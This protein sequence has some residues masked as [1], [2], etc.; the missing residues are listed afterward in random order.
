MQVERTAVVAN[1]LK[2]IELVSSL[3]RK[4][5][6]VN[7]SITMGSMDMIHWTEASTTFCGL[8]NQL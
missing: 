3:D 1:A 4:H 8:S 6:Y 5:V 2:D 7:Y